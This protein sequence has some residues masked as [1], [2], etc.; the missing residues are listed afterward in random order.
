MSNEELAEL[1]QGGIDV[2]KNMEALYKQMSGLIAKIAWRYRSLEEVE[3]LKQEGYLGLYKAAL[4]FSP[5]AGVPF[6]QYAALWI[7]QKIRRY[8]ENCGSV[9]RIPSGQ[10]KLLYQYRKLCSS[11]LQ[12]LGR[13]PTDREAAFN[14]DITLQQAEQLKQDAVMEKL[15]S[16]DI[17]VDEDRETTL[18]D[19]Q[20]GSSGIEDDILDRINEEELKT[21]L[22]VCV[23]ELEESQ[24]Q[25]II[26]RY[27]NGYTIRQTGEAMGITLEA[28]RQQ[29]QKGLKE[30]RKPSKA[31]RIKPYL[32]EYAYNMG[33]H[34]TGAGNFRRTWTSATERTAIKL[35]DSL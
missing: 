7:R 8:I 5:A 2:T 6:Y 26:H 32:D 34:G 27:K 18:G 24:Q 12:E 9:V 28:A 10:K 11:Y 19:L 31:K 3:D 35:I 13:Q 21:V 25:A 33:I 22:W 15:G 4:A 23:D 1:I 20:A 17:S 14:L 29:E 16:L 30:L